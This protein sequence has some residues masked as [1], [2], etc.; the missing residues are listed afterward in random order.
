MRGE[1]GGGELVDAQSGKPVSELRVVAVGVEQC[2]GPVRFNEFSVG[3]RISQ[4]AVVVVRLAGELENPARHRNGYAVGG[5][6]FHERV[7]PFPGRFD[8]DRAIG[9][10]LD[11]VWRQAQGFLHL[12]QQIGVTG[13]R[14][15]V[16]VVR[17]LTLNGEQH[18][19][20]GCGAW[21]ADERDDEGLVD[22][23]ACGICFNPG[24]EEQIRQ[25]L[26]VAEC[27][28]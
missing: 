22:C 12:N 4:P 14:E 28:Q 24:E 15:L 23:P 20:I 27:S 11:P 16:H 18:T 2:V 8:C 21:I 26:R 13:P 7:E 17:S 19:I 5:E 1:G 9:H 3:D 6:L 25:R 10:H